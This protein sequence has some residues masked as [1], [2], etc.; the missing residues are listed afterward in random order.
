MACRYA[1]LSSP[2]SALASS[3]ANY[4]S[5]QRANDSDAQPRAATYA[6]YASLRCFVQ[7]KI[8]KISRCARTW[9]NGG[10]DEDCELSWRGHDDWWSARVRGSVV[11]ASLFRGRVRRQELQRLHRDTYEAGL[12]EPSPVFLHGHQGRRRKSRK[13]VVSN[14]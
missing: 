5:R 6:T 4:T 1:L 11:C 9:R 8:D 2:R 12:A 7:L 10:F 3:C 14:L 13:L